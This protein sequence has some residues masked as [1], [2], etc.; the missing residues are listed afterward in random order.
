MKDSIQK[1]LF[2]LKGE[3]GFSDHTVRGY[4]RDLLQFEDYLKDRFKIEEV[5]GIGRSEVREYLGSLMRYGYHERSI[6]RKLSS[7]KSFFRFLNRES[8]IERN[9][10]HALRTPKNA[11]GKK[12][13]PSFLPLTDTLELLKTPDQNSKLGKRD[14]AILE[15]LYGTGMR[16]SEL[17]GLNREDV[18]IYGEEIKVRGKGKKERILPLGRM[19]KKVLLEYM[20]FTKPCPEPEIASPAEKRDRNDRRG[21]EARSHVPSRRL[22]LPPKD[23]IAMTGEGTSHESPVFLNRF[24][25]RLTSRSLQRIVKKY[26]RITLGGSELSRSSP[27][28]LRHTFATHMVERGADLRAVQELLGHSSLSTTQ[29]YSHLTS[30]RLKEVYRRSHP[31]G[32]Q[33]T[34]E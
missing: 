33:K 31:K 15:L 16:S 14:Q 2:H 25:S 17:V 20:N 34:K 10:V 23:G 5:K 21:N 7:L 26:I 24:G 13:L 8:I 6:A 3:R 9:P 28:L 27:H 4:E 22:L 1:F 32:D 11:S 29:I 18:D 19:A 30:K 12:R